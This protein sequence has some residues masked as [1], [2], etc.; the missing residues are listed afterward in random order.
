MTIKEKSFK[1]VKYKRGEHPNSLANL[2]KFLPGQN[3]NHNLEGYSITSEIKQQLKEDSEFIAPHARPRD[4]GWRQQIAR[5]IL[6]KAASGDVAMVK[7]LLD[8]TEGKV[9]GDNVAI[10]FNEIRVL[11]VEAPPPSIEEAQ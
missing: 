1:L 3:G 8:R 11:V 9:P 6:A 5:E 2:E 10:N 4:K 7:E